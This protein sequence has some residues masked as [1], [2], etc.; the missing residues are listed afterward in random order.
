MSVQPKRVLFVCTSN[1]ARSQVAAAYFNK[2]FPEGHADSAGTVV[3]QEDQT[4][5]DYGAVT[6]PKVLAEEGIDATNFRRHQV[7]QAM[8][9][10]YDKIVVMADKATLPDWLRNHPK[11]EYW[12]IFDPRVAD[13]NV[14]RAVFEQIRAKVMQ[15]VE[16][17]RREV[18]A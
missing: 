8:L 17:C 6:T 3:E 9:A 14:T 1:V 16:D 13:S 15:L 10:G 7:T 18:Q 11:F 12:E 2:F 5:I 4:I